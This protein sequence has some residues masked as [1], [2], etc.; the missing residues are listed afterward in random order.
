MSE[1]E[2]KRQRLIGAL[3][4]ALAAGVSF[5][6]VFAP[7]AREDEIAALILIDIN[8]AFGRVDRFTR[9]IDRGGQHAPSPVDGATPE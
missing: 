8:R 1:I 9:A 5:R 2:E 3:H 6:N 4:G 7:G